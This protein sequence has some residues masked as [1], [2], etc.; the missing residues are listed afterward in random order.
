MPLG[1]QDRMFQTLA[2]VMP[3]NALFRIGQDGSRLLFIDPFVSNAGPVFNSLGS[4]EVKRMLPLVI[5]FV[6][7]A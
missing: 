5:G 6:P 4:I 3:A 7:I 2:L 1:G